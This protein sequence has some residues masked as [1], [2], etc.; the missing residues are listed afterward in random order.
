MSKASLWIMESA[1]RRPPQCFQRW[2]L[3][4][5]AV[6]REARLTI[7][8]RPRSW[9]RTQKREGII[10]LLITSTVLI[11][12]IWRL[13]QHITAAFRL[14][15]ARYTHKPCA[16]FTPKVN[17]IYMIGGAHVAWKTKEV[18]I[19]KTIWS[20]ERK[21][22]ENK[23]GGRREWNKEAVKYPERENRK[24]FGVPHSVMNQKTGTS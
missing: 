24:T 18:R 7:K 15:T 23:K 13:K 5:S 20:E 12:Y 14:H 3:D 4:L 6:L 22:R 21:R 1:G 8:S 16:I 19:N 17:N 11:D 2:T 10:E 9:R